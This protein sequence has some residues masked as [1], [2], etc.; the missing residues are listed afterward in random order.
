MIVCGSGDC[1]GD[2]SGDRSG[3]GCEHVV[4]V[5]NML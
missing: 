1:S 5:V 2:G 4:M 3:D